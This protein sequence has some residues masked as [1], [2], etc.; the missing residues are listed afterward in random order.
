MATVVHHGKN[1]TFSWTDGTIT[2]EAAEVSWVIE[3]SG[4]V[5]DINSADETNYEAKLAGFK[6]WTLSVDVI[7]SATL[8]NEANLFGALGHATAAA[9][10]IT[11]NGSATETYTATAAILIGW[12]KQLEA[13]GLVKHTFN[14]QGSGAL[15]VASG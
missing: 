2:I 13:T 14:F 7:D 8:L 10:L 1:S 11:T 5:I 15:V 4:E 3:V 6:T 9:T 12:S